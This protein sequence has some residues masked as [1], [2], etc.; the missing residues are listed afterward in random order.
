MRQVG[1]TT[2]AP[3]LWQVKRP[4]GAFILKE[5]SATQLGTDW[6]KSGTLF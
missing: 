4:F 5:N 2:L 3:D 1:L 6:A